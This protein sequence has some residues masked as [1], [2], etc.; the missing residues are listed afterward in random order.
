MGIAP[1]EPVLKLVECPASGKQA[2]FGVW[3]VINV[4]HVYGRL[5]V[6]RKRGDIWEKFCIMQVG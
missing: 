6:A 2:E 4:G 3:S 1:P 5:Q